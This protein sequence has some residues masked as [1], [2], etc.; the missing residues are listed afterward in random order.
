MEC[1]VLAFIPGTHGL[2]SSVVTIAHSE[3]GQIDYDEFM[4]FLEVDRSPFS[5]EPSS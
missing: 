1:V 4:K 5:G 3:S 2:W